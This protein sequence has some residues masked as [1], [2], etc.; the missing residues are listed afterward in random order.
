MTD[1]TKLPGFRWMPGMRD[2]YGVRVAWVKP[3]VSPEY[4]GGI[5]DGDDRTR[6]V[7]AALSHDSVPDL[8]DPATRGCLLELVRDAWAHDWVWVAPSPPD[9][10]P[11]AVWSWRG[12][13]PAVVAAGHT[14][15]EA[16]ILA[17]EAA[18]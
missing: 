16:L 7:N 15:A 9:R 1:P 5:R 3:D 8:T 2:Q 11:W 14:Q 17:L 18:P 12:G 10:L 6:P 4:I 13:N